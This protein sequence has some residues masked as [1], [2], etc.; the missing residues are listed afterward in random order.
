MGITPL[1]PLVGV[2]FYGIRHTVALETGLAL[3]RIHTNHRNAMSGK[4]SEK[5][6]IQKKRLNI[7]LFSRKYQASARTGSLSQ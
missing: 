3:S 7:F 2:F 1:A 5:N 4:C 6:N